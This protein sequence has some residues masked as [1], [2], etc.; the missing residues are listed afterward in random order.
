MLLLLQGR[1]LGTAPQFFDTSAFYYVSCDNHG[2]VAPTITDWRTNH[3][4]TLP[5]NNYKDAFVPDCL[6]AAVLYGDEYTPP[7]IHTT[8]NTHPFV[9]YFF[10]CCTD[11]S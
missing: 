8:T 9:L 6:G 10:S 2:K 1:L 7:L 3:E 4:A 5:T 11:S